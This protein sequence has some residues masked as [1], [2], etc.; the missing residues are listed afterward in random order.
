[1][2]GSVHHAVNAALSE[3]IIVVSRMVRDALSGVFFRALACLSLMPSV[4]LRLQGRSFS[5][6]LRKN[7]ACV[8]QQLV[9]S[10]KK[11]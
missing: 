6:L 10:L 8:S 7:T 11:P 1:M 5:A 4:L 2:S 9:I 3:D